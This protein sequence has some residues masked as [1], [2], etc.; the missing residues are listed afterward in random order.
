MRLLILYSQFLLILF[1]S[2]CNMKP[3]TK[4][5]LGA[6][7]EITNTKNIID[8]LEIKVKELEEEIESRKL[9]LTPEKEAVQKMALSLINDLNHIYEDK[10]PA[11]VLKYFL[12][13]FSINYV[14]VGSDNKA[15]ITRLSSA[16]YKTHLR[17]QMKEK[18]IKIRM[19]DVVVYDIE[20]KGNIFSITL[21]NYSEVYKHGKLIINR[22]VHTTITGREQ[23]GWK[24][25]DLSQVSIDY[26][27]K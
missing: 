22:S 10:K 16:D 2:G 6:T 15:Q 21:K 1:I 23:D 14:F 20:I 13:E 3:E 24:I 27:V 11:K 26:E 7:N 9:V 19:G 17:R 25:G 8:S 5:V 4:E 12:T 18:N